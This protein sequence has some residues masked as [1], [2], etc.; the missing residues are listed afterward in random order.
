MCVWDPWVLILS[1][2]NFFS[3]A[4]ETGNESKSRGDVGFCNEHARVH[5]SRPHNSVHHD[6]A[7]TALVILSFASYSVPTYAS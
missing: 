1:T 4:K 3:T 5:G 2:L 6:I 7:P